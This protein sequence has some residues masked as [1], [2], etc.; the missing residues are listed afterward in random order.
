[1][2][3]DGDGSRFAPAMKGGGKFGDEGVEFSGQSGQNMVK[4]EADAVGILESD[5][6]DDAVAECF[7]GFVIRQKTGGIGNS[8]KGGGQFDLRSREVRHFDEAGFPPLVNRGIAAGLRI[9]FVGIIADRGKQGEVIP[10]V[11][12]SRPRGM[13][14]VNLLI[15][16]AFAAERACG[17]MLDAICLVI[18]RLRMKFRMGKDG[19][20]PCRRAVFLRLGGRYQY[21][22]DQNS[23]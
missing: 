7:A 12:R 19:L 21:R 20:L 16:N 5:K 2:Q 4:I 3:N 9:D 14:S 13:P 1:M 11:G 6:G 17:G 8:G 15:Q 18:F 22:Q 10:L 23:E